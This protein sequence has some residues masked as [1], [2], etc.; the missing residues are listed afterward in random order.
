MDNVLK[1][2]YFFHLKHYLTRGKGLSPFG[3]ISRAL[4]NFPLALG[5]IYRISPQASVIEAQVIKCMLG[6]VIKFDLI[7]SILQAKW[8]VNVAHALELMKQS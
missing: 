3:D 4:I 5:G 2:L 7:V 8:F 6:I 1:A